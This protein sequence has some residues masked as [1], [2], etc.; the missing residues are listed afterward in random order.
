MIT[1]SF[2]GADFLNPYK[3]VLVLGELIVVPLVASRILMWTHV[4]RRLET[5]RGTIINWAFFFFNYILVG[6]NRD[7]FLHKPFSL[8]PVAVIAFASTFL[9]GWVIEKVSNLMKIDPEIRTSLVLLGTLK[10]YGIAGGVAITLFSREAAMPST[11][12][13]VVMI[14]YVVWLQYRQGSR[15]ARGDRRVPLSG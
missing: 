15:S 5:V 6:L 7:I 3:M 4:D 2:V 14:L 11:V 13:A 9:L 1:L 8:L 10:N 12:S